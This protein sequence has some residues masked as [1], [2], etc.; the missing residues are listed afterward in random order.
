MWLESWSL[1][2][3]R[4]LSFLSSLLSFPIFLA[5]LHE[6]YAQESGDFVTLVKVLI[7][8]VG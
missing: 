3:Q 6:Y 2:M 1:L 7:G 5:S 8:G 4:Y